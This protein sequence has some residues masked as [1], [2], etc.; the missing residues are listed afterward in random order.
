MTLARQKSTS[1]WDMRLSWLLR[2]TSKVCS[3]PVNKTP[4]GTVRIAF[5]LDFGERAT[6]RFQGQT[7]KIGNV[8]TWHRQ[9][10]TFRNCDHAR[11]PIAPVDKKYGNFFLCR[12]TTT[13]P[14]P[15]QVDGLQIPS[16]AA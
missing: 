2:L 5:L 13:D 1:L 4:L 7:E 10:N 16:I 12:S 8:L 11:H 6:D 9:G 14:E 3:R 15:S